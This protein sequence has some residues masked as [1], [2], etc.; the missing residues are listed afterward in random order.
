MTERTRARTRAPWIV[1]GIV[2]TLLLVALS[3]AFRNGNVSKDALAIVVSIVMMLGYLTTGAIVSSRARNRLGWLMIAVGAGFLVSVLGQE[4]ATYAIRTS[5]GSLPRLVVDAGIIGANVGF[6]AALWPIPMLLAVFPTGR[7]PS[8][9]WRWFPPALSVGFALLAIGSILKAGPI[10]LNTGVQPQNPTGIPSITGA[11][12]AILVIGGI[13]TL[14]LSLLSV[15][16]L[17][18]RFRASRGEE[19]Q[20]LRWLASV[21]ALSLVAF[22]AA[23]V[24]SVGLGPNETTFLS[25]AAWFVLLALIG[26]GVPAAIGIALLRYRL[27]DL[28]VVVR[29]TV[30]AAIVVVLI[31]T[32][33]LLALTFVGAAFVGPVSDS[34]P[35]FLFA[36]VAVGLAFWPLRKLAKRISDRVVYGG[37]ATP[38]D[39]LTE[40]SDRMSETYSTEDVLPRMAAIVADGTR[41]DRVGIWVLVGREMQAAASWPPESAGEETPVDLGEGSFEVRHHDELLGAITVLMP[42]ADPMNPSKEK[43]IRDLASQAGLVLRNVRLIEELRASRRRIVTTQDE[44]AKALER[45]IHDGAQQQLVALAVKLRLAEGFARTDPERTGSMLSDLQAEANDALENLRDLARGIYPPLL[46]DQGLPSALE[47]QARKSPVPVDVQARGVDRYPQEI[48][49]AVY[50]SCLEA[51]QNVAKYAEASSASVELA[52]EDGHLTFRVTDDGR[53][54]DATTRTYGTGLQG[55]ADRLDSIGG[56]L[57]VTS[58]P[59]RGT[60]V[61]GRIPTPAR[62]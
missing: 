12:N 7:V 49:S 53:G 50:F 55:M 56:T 44:R 14:V 11:V 21:A 54:F 20:Q 36:G 24:T 31:T 1:W 6:V 41:A 38:Y 46:A 30:V 9:R 29:K 15:V 61:A 45:N 17:I 5:P 2:V 13:A 26:L 22:V 3:L 48:E 40:F 32:L 60:I 10:D 42:A 34:S 57:E 16:I 18:V 37:R 33:A 28:D 51:L 43:L 39:V 52:H 23:F 62:D 59:G 8:R 19:R 25:N 4:T 47:A 58:S 35:S 27:W